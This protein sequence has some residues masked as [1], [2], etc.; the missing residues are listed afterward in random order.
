MKVIQLVPA[1]HYGDAVGN[2]TLALQQTLRQAGYQTQIYAQQ[3]APRCAQF[4]KPLSQLSGVSHEDVAIY[5]MATGAEMTYT[6]AKLPCKKILVYHNMTPPKFF[7]PYNPTVAQIVQEGLEQVQYLAGHV[8]YCLAVSPFNQQDLIDMGY[9]CPIDVLPILIP[10]EDYAREPNAQ[11]MERFGDGRTNFV[12]TGRVAPNKKHEDIIA[13][14]DC[15]K[16][17]CDASARLFLVGS[18][19]AEDLYFQ[20]LQQYVA[21]LET[22]DV[23]F[24]GHIGF[25]EILAYYRIADCLVCMSEHEGFCVPLVEAMYFDVP[26]IAYASTA[27]PSTLQGCGLMVEDKDPLLVAKLMERIVHDQAL[28]Q[29]VLQAQRERLKDFSHDKIERQFLAYL[30]AFIGD[31]A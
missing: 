9:T 14:F 27:I 30:Q 31:R 10:F 18:F 3:I 7:A 5:H 22:Q 15:Y 25:D 26:I 19:Q 16:R 24:T 21:A 20:R 1:L 12:F 11:V 2:D 8:D 13:A 23:V 4:A 17:Q 28:R 29:T 6:F